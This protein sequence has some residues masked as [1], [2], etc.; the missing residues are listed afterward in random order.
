[1]KIKCNELMYVHK[2]IHENIYIW[3]NEENTRGDE[4]VRY[5]DASGQ[6]GKLVNV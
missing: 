1:M 6:A 3:K 5:E 2:H 4:N